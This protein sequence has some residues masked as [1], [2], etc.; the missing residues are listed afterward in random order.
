MI[1]YQEILKK[2]FDSLETFQFKRAKDKD[3]VHE[4]ISK[5]NSYIRTNLNNWIESINLTL[6]EDTQSE[7]F[8]FFRNTVVKITASDITCIPYSEIDAYVWEEQIIPRDFTKDQP[9]CPQELKGMFH[10]FLDYICCSEPGSSDSDYQGPRSPES[11]MSFFGSMIHRYKDPTKARCYVILDENLDREERTDGRT[12]KSLLARSATHVRNVLVDN[13]RGTRLSDRFTFSNVNLD[14]NLIVVDDANAN[15]DLSRLFSLITGDFTSERKFCD[16]I[17]IPFEN[18]PK[19]VI[20]SNHSLRGEGDSF[21]ARQVT[22]V[23]SNVFSGEFGPKDL[24]GTLFENWSD[25]EWNR[26]FNT[27]AM[28][29]QIYLKHGIIPQ[30]MPV[31]WFILKSKSPEGL[32]ELFDAELVTARRY[33]KAALLADYREKLHALKL[34]EQHSFTTLLKKYAEYR[35]WEVSETHSGTVNYITFSEKPA[36]VKKIDKEE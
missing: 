22:Y 24:I 25:E 2:L 7:S 15:F 21:N 30:Q 5:S 34:V 35:G 26:F 14:T 10:Q 1:S 18:S 33:D 4:K 29:V 11:I 36:K 23:I 32:I 19:F 3:L 8:L 17:T 6:L 20:T 12:G 28:C 16:P 9:E 13:G 27:V 31:S